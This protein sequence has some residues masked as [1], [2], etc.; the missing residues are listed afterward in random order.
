M[1]VDK[2]MGDS[3]SPFDTPPTPL[4]RPPRKKEEEEEEEEEEEDVSEEDVMP[5]IDWRRRWQ[6]GAVT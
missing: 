4:V 1:S 3:P 6:S 2:S 5:K